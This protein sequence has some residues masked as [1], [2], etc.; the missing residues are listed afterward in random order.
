[1]SLKSILAAALSSAALLFASTPAFAYSP[2]STGLL[3][4]DK[5]VSASLGFLSSGTATLAPEKLVLASD[6]LA[7]KLAL[8]SDVLVT[9]DGLVLSGAANGLSQKRPFDWL[10]GKGDMTKLVA[11]NPYRKVGTGP[12]RRYTELLPPLS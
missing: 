9:G 2:A 8:T 5:L 6:V 3:A 1:M 11:W 10:R 4:P 7:P 12:Y